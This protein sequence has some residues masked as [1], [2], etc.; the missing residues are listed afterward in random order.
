MEWR[1]TP[2]KDGLSPSQKLMSR[3]TRT[4]IPVSQQQ[5]LF[6]SVDNNNVKN[7]ITLRKR[8]A[9][10]YY[11]RSA[12]DLP[13][14][15]VGDKVRLQPQDPK[16]AWSKGCCVGKVG[17]RSYLVETDS[18][19]YRRNRKFLRSANFKGDIDSGDHNEDS[20]LR[21]ETSVPQPLNDMS[22]KEEKTAGNSNS[23]QPVKP[24]TPK[25]D[26]VPE[27]NIKTRSGR[28]VRKP[29]RYER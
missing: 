9:K 21:L 5:L 26:T 29:K 1:N 13:E 16:A 24:K 28:V 6:S 15:Q 11:D 19:V 14:L 20:S 12:K 22:R 7:N 23:G 2:G 8:N 10:F 3:R 18:G 27:T 4:T 25:K 17:P